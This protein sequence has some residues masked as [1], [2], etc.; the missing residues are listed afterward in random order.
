MLSENLKNLR[1]EQ[2]YSRKQLSEA[3]GVSKTTIYMIENDDNYDPKLSSL[4]A[5]AKVL[6][7]PISKLL[8]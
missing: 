2:R 5:L 3:A 8:K 7:V 1:I 4:T 6:K